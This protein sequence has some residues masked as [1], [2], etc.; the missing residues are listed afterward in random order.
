MQATE[1]A[2]HRGM[3]A[4]CVVDRVAYRY[5]HGVAERKEGDDDGEA[6]GRDPLVQ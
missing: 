2:P 5:F 1:R 6:T 4:T 3:E